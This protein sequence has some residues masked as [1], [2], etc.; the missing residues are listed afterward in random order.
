MMS[1]SA[2]I[3]SSG[4]SSVASSTYNSSVEDG[5]YS[6]NGGCSAGLDDITRLNPFTF[7]ECKSGMGGLGGDAASAASR[8]GSYS[9]DDYCHNPTSSPPTPLN[10]ATDSESGMAVP[11]I[12]GNFEPLDANHLPKYCRYQF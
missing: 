2:M 10:N 6:S 1:S 8:N 3:D 5:D 11:R 12:T 9:S 7:G 4:G